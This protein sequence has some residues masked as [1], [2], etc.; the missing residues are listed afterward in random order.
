MIKA[1]LFDLDGTLCDSDTAWSIA[2]KETFQLL[3]KQEPSISEEAIANAWRTVH[4]RLFQQ[5]GAGKLSMAEVRDARFQCLFEEL[6]LPIDRMM[7]ELSDF[8]CSRYLTGLR[9]YEDV[10]VL[11]KLTGYHVGI[12]TNGAH[13]AHTDSQLSK[14]RHLGLSER[15]QSLTISG[16]IG[17]RKPKVEIF[18]VA[19]ERADVLPEEAM[20]I[21]DS[22]QNDIVGANRAG[23]TSVLINRKSEVLIP[24]ST[25][26]QPDYTVSSLHEVL[27]CL[28]SI[29]N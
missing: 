17:V 9:L 19:C 24:E 22:I 13:D 14:V 12:I 7:E 16:E 27:S 15:I 4:Q 21:G 11:E 29:Q 1:V 20:Y 25:D 3:C 2:V 6:D 23:M 10:T 18:K 28:G 5:L 26:E 8:F